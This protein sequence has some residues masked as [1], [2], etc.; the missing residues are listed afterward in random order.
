MS[1]ESKSIRD[2]IE[3]INRTY[4]LPA[5]QREFVWDTYRVE[6]LFDSVVGD[7]PISSF[8]FWKVKE[9]NK[10]DWISYEFLRN[11]NQESPH[12]IEAD[13]SGVNK[14]IYL[15][16]DGQQRLTALNIGLRGSYRYFYYR[17]RKAELFLNLLKPFGRNDENPEELEFQFQFR[18][19]PQ[20]EYPEKEL[21]YKVGRI[22][23][24]MDSEDAKSNIKSEIAA[25]N[26]QQK[27]N[28]QKLV[29]RLHARIHTFKL[30]NYYEEK[31]Q[32]YDKVVEVFIRANTGG[33][34]LEYSDILLS[35]ATAKWKN[36]NAR[37]EIYNF[38]DDIN[39][40]GVGYNFGK[41]FVLK[42]CLY[43]TEGLPIQYKV[44]NF[45]R[46]NLEKIENNWLDIKGGIEN[47]I[48]L[49]SK[50]G[51]NNKNITA[52]MALLPIAF[53][54]IKLNKNNYI[55][56]FSKEDVEN[57]TSIQ[58][59]LILA[60]LKNSFGG[61]SDTTLSN[62][63]SE[64]INISDY[65]KF[66]FVELNKK[67][68]IVA[69]FTDEELENLLSMNY[70][71]KYSF[72]ILS[73]L[74][75]DRDWKDSNYHEDHIYPK[76]LF[77]AAKLKAREFDEATVNEYQKYYNTILNLQLLTDSENIEKNATDFDSWI[78]TRDNNFKIRHSI[79][80]I[81]S[82][83]FEEFVDFIN[84]R[85]KILQGKLKAI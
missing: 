67:L 75:P 46:S 60:L 28:A 18:E 49:I 22:L 69:S 30:V 64:L 9:D 26:E 29:G 37:D 52:A 85:K 63:R 13:L 56:S 12:N 33:K 6:K 59:W 71:T 1:Y 34:T 78:S 61:S 2:A 4:F 17:W 48:R 77:S 76:S 55:N 68:G 83:K 31:S 58:K 45:T 70:K 72:L 14:D 38:T 80:D 7:Y 20:S 27:E 44:G 42:G 3:E 32:E 47:T 16:L 10:K 25:F 53:Y 84:E 41:D 36:L 21:W 11:Y 50:F 39:T 62:L 19:L 65:S 82:Y 51:F 57:Q 15:V 81:D 54:L 24:F 5:I 40:I 73:L 23:D 35:T 8:L 43:L 74:Y 79:P 66:P